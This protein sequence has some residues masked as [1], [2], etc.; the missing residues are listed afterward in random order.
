MPRRES[1]SSEGTSEVELELDSPDAATLSCAMARTTASFLSVAVIWVVSFAR[2]AS[3]SEQASSA[4]TSSALLAELLIAFGWLLLVTSRIPGRNAA[5][6]VDCVRRI[7]GGMAY[8]FDGWL[9]GSGTL[10]LFFVSTFLR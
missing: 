7:S 6:L 3:N 1:A 8:A 5:G 4:R 10:A 9:T 2:S